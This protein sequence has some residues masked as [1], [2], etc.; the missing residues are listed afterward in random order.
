MPAVYNVGREF[1]C[2]NTTFRDDDGKTMGAT[3]AARFLL[4]PSAT[5]QSCQIIR[6]KLDVW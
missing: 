1:L 3:L 6:S 5:S 2:T 4:P